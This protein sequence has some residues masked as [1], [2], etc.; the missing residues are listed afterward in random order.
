MSQHDMEQVRQVARSLAYRVRSEPAFRENVLE[1]PV[2]ALTAAGLPE[3]F[4]S[5]FMHE[6]QLSE[7]VGYEMEQQC[8]ISDIGSL[9]DFIY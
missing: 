6:T 3:E 5:T 7:V 4:I 1:N 9:Q 2:A 8:L